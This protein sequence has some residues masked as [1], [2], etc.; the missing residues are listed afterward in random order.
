MTDADKKPFFQV[1]ARLAIA[2]R[3]KDKPD[4]LEYLAYVRATVK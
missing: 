1:F 3:G 4:P 2:L